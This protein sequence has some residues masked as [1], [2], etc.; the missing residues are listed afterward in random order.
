M[1]QGGL[2]CALFLKAARPPVDT[3]PFP[4]GLWA[5]RTGL[6]VHRGTC[7]NGSGS[8]FC[9]TG[10]KPGLS[11]AAILAGR[12]MRGFVLTVSSQREVKNNTH[13]QFS[14]RYAQLCLLFPFLT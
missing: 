9:K 3:A 4:R 12:E 11:S 8:E 2:V 6:C 13:F 5:A 1:H 14:I 10:G 7:V